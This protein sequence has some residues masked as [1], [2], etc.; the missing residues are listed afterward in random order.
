MEVLNQSRGIS[1]KLQGI[2]LY[3]RDIEVIY[4]LMS[5]GLIKPEIRTDE[6]IFT[7]PDDLFHHVHDVDISRL[8]I[9]DR[10]RNIFIRIGEFGIDLSAND[11]SDECRGR[12]AKIEDYL[13][14]R[15]R[16]LYKIIGVHPSVVG[17]L[18][19]PILLPL[20]NLF[21]DNISDCFS[22]QCFRKPIVD[23]IIAVIFFGGI[24]GLMNWYA[25]WRLPKIRLRIKVD[26][27]NS[28]KIFWSGNRDKIFVALIIA[29]LLFPL[30]I[31]ILLVQRK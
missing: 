10:E 4:D 14:T 9:S 7:D 24:F 11:N 2:V 31:I 25:V 21:F 15:Q 16:N 12:L 13:L 27:S 26:E 30:Q 28:I 19:I 20:Y 8:S 1:R 23:I 3:R 6:A 17:C 29:F 5:A 22:G 18:G